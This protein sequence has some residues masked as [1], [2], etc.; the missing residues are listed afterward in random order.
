MTINFLFGFFGGFF[1]VGFAQIKE[2]FPMKGLIVKTS[3]I[4]LSSLRRTPRESL[5]FSNRRRLL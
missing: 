2:L 3:F 1:I 5:N 4:R